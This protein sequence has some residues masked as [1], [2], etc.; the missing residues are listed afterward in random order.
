MP[1]IFQYLVY[2]IEYFY[3]DLNNCELVNSKWFYHVWNPQSIYYADITK[4]FYLTGS[5]NGTNIVNSSFIRQWQRLMNVK[6]I[7]LDGFRDQTDSKGVLSTKFN[8]P[9]KN[10]LIFEKITS[11]LVNVQ[12]LPLKC[13]YKYNRNV[14]LFWQ[15]LG[16]T[17]EK[18]NGKVE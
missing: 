14:M 11:N 4:L 16:P 8:D 12:R 3:A 15:L 17:L 5:Y 10:K 6:H 9:S 1:C 18:N 2:D 7:R 13:W